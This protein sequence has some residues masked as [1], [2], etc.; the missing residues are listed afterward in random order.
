[1]SRERVT[2]FLALMAMGNAGAGRSGQRAPII[3]AVLSKGCRVPP[4]SFVP[5]PPLLACRLRR[6]GLLSFPL[7][8]SLYAY[9]SERRR[10]RLEQRVSFFPCPLFFDCARSPSTD[11]TLVGLPSPMDCLY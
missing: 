4:A 3:L 10:R 7:H 1:M 11:W 2:I 9:L 8:S 5:P 6:I